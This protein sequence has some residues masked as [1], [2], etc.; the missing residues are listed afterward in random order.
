MTIAPPDV[1][2]GVF[3]APYN[4]DLEAS[5]G[6]GDYT[7]TLV[8]GSNLPSGVTLA[9]NG[10]INGSPTETGS[11]SFSVDVIDGQGNTG[12]AVYSLI[13]FP[14]PTLLT[15]APATLPDGS[16]DT[17]YSQQLTASGG[18]GPYAYA[19]SS[20][21]LPAGLALSAGGLI[22]GD[23]SETG[24]FP[25]TVKATDA[26]GNMG[27]QAYTLAIDPV[28]GIITITPDALPPGV[29]GEAY[30]DVTLGASGGS[31]SGYD[32][33]I[34]AGT[35][36]AGIAFDTDDGTFSGTPTEVGSFPITVEVTDDQGNTGQKAYT[37]TVVPVDNL[38]ITPDTVPDGVFGVAYSQQLSAT[39]GDGA[40][41]FSLGSGALPAGVTLSGAGLISGTPTETGDFSF[42]VDVSDGQ[43]PS[44][45]G[46]ETYTLTVAA[47][48]DLL[49]I[50]PATLPDGSFDTAYSQQLTA[51]GRR[52][53]LR[54]RPLLGVV[55]SRARAERRRA[56]LGRSE[57]DRL[58]PGHGQGHRRRGQYGRAGLYAGDRPGLRD[59]HH[60][61]GR[62][63][64]GR[65]R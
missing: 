2:N 18:V 44:N 45:T 5:G 49:T 36:P 57:R 8:A 7:F 22:S 25:V 63:A 58:L 32:G 48:S 35:L 4:V 3:G 55:A 59:H 14:V 56:D 6:D 33:E 13:V 17:A 62:A 34:I 27:E 43:S 41:V 40:Y 24:S 9:P 53:A 51:S 47:D 60:H 23:P 39:G 61:A 16:F 30:P 26:E 15:I 10:Q 54:L 38:Q 31:G 65:V 29:F 1:P 46:Q 50:A 20:G 21:S 37:L 11:F 19:L 42:Q 12:L 64:A 28:S 52:R